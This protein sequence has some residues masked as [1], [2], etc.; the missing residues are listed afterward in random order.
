MKF[1]ECYHLNI[2]HLDEQI[3]PLRDPQTNGRVEVGFIN[4]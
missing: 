3:E 2:K 1:D 4:S